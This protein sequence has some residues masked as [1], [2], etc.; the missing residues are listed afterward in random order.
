M[1][2]APLLLQTV[3]ILRRCRDGL[4]ADAA[5][6][7][8]AR[9]FPDISQSARR[10]LAHSV[11]AY[12]R[13]LG[14]MKKGAGMKQ[15]IKD[16]LELDALHRRDPN[17]I[18]K[19]SLPAHAVPGWV[20]PE[21]DFGT[22]AGADERRFGW[23]RSLQYRAP[24]WLRARPGAADALDKMLGDCEAPAAASRA[25][26][27]DALE[28]LGEHDLFQNGLFQAGEFQIQDLASQAVGTLCAPQPGENWWDA[29]SGEGGKS[30]HLADL[31]RNKGTVWCSDRSN[32]RLETLR[33][34]FG[35][36]KL[37]NYRVATWDGLT[38]PKTKAKYD[39][40]LVDAPCSGVGTWARNPDARWTVTPDD[41]HEL[42]M[43]QTRLLDLVSANVKPGGR[44]IY[45]VCTITRR[46]TTG[47]AEN[48]SAAHPDFEPL[49]L[50]VP[51][52]AASVFLW[53]HEHRS[54]GMFVAG[55]RR[56]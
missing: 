8:Y 56:R 55:W 15:H 26:A 22:D 20:L 36:A 38:K 41:V 35:R 14:W 39:G 30:L 45:A 37:F 54:N 31:M 34:R 25:L 21:I 19:Q 28:Y 7:D 6:R 5:L 17:R 1:P 40:V 27:P 16:A 42:A 3:E 47:V 9:V 51:S 13:W 33:A 4:N 46:E 53:P 12:F 43:V 24:L 10:D 23:L 52:G 48:F 49:P 2:A 29:C 11:F 32:R 50:A 18:K 44:L